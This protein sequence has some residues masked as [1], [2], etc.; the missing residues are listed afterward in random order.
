M[1]KYLKLIFINLYY[2]NSLNQN[3]FWNNN[4]HNGFKF[5]KTKFHRFF[6]IK[7]SLFSFLHYFILFFFINEYLILKKISMRRTTFCKINNFNSRKKTKLRS[8]LYRP[9]CNK[10]KFK[11]VTKTKWAIGSTYVLKSNY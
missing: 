4:Y 3:C 6:L 7:V 8:N 2:L 5:V 11:Y 10:K 1:S 9:C